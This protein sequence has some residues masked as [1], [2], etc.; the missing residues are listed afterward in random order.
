M[1]TW[2]FVQGAFNQN[3]SKCSAKNSYLEGFATIYR[4]PLTFRT[5]SQ[6]ASSPTLYLCPALG[7]ANQNKQVIESNYL[8]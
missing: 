1:N 5:S 3:Q 7:T 4:Y 6:S 2:I 8:T